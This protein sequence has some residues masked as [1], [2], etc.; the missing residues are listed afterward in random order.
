MAVYTRISDSDFSDVVARYDVGNFRAAKGIAEGVENTNYLLETDRCKY[1]FTAY[2][3]RLNPKDLPFFLALMQHLAE[4][5]IPCPVP[6]H[7][8]DGEVLQEVNGKRAS[9]VSFLEGKWPKSVRNHHCREVGK[10]LGRMHNAVSDFPLSR[11]NTMGVSAWRSLFSE[12]SGHMEKEFP[13]LEDELRVSLEQIEA[14]W[15]KKQALP[16]GVI[17]AD[18]FPDN[19]FFQGEKLSGILDFYFACNDFF[20][21]DLAIALNAWCFEHGTEFNITKAKRL[22]S[23]YN[24]ERVMTKEEVEYL[25]ILAAGASL[26][27]LLTRLYDWLHRVEGA[28]VV[29]KDPTEYLQKLRF[30]QNVSSSAEYGLE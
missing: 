30:H 1:I 11:P 5:G 6:I 8:R 3:K 25:P 12:M 7:A 20:A 16:D 15:P 29:P 17:H 14:K 9:M 13:G 19:V 18:I 4:A 2:E 23:G 24:S 21:Y 27:F 26:R 22:L 28:M 10:I